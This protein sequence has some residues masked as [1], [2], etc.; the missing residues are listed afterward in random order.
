MRLRLAIAFVCSCVVGLGSTGAASAS[1]PGGF[2]QLPGAAGCVSG[3]GAGGCTAGHGF[4]ANTSV[5]ISPD[6]R[7]AYVTTFF[8][9]NSVLVF[10][11]DPATGALTQ[12]SGQD[13]CVHVT[14]PTADCA[15][16][17]LMHDP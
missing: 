17:P 2:V 13:G 6:G 1:I 15:S 4:G 16:A 12:K 3:G 5:A 14:A 9:S 7:N 11:R 8:G 10:D